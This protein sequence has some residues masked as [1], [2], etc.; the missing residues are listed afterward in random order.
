MTQFLSFTDN[1]T[2]PSER[3]TVSVD[4]L[5]D[6]EVEDHH[7]S[8]NFENEWLSNFS[9]LGKGH[10]EAWNNLIDLIPTLHWQQCFVE[11]ILSS[12]DEI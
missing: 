5:R 9:L 11:L 4:D 8:G 3:Q 7:Y 6:Q 2:P 10:C 1:L 12:E